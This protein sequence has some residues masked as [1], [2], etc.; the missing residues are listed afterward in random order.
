MSANFLTVNSS[1]T[2]CLINGLK[3][4]L[5]K[6]RNSSLNTSRSACNLDFIF[7]E[8]L[9]FSDQISSLSKSCYS[10]IRELVCIHSYFDSKTASTIAASIIQSTLDY[11]N[12]LNNNLP[13]Q[14]NRL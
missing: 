3:K 5:F 1:K 4:Q 6:I 12:S 14:L 7:D 8:N 13:S 10:H 9:T 11:C 2:E